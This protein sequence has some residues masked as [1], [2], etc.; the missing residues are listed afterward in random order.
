MAALQN[1]T[2]APLRLQSLDM[3]RGL[4]VAL[5]IV[6]NTSGDG[7]HTFPQLAHSK[8]NG[9]TLADVVF[10]CFLFMVGLSARL[11]TAS[12]LARGA[13]RSELILQAAHR[14]ATLFLLGLAVNSFP[15]F[16]LDTLRIFGVLQ[17]IALCYFLVTCLI[18]FLRPR[19]LSVLTILLLTGYWMILRWV[20][21]PGLGRPVI[22]V[23]FLDR[24]A[25]LPAWLDRHLLSANHL[26]RQTTYDPEGLL[27]SFSALS[28]TMIGGLTGVWI[29]S[30]QTAHAIARGLLLAGTICILAGL[31]W[32]PWFPLNKRLWTSSFV[33]FTAGI[34]ILVLWIFYRFV[35][36]R[37][38]SRGPWTLPL[39]VF[40]TNALPAYI[41]SEFLAS[42]LSAIHLN[43][44]I[45]LQRWLYSPLPWLLHNASVAALAYAILF[46][47]VCFIPTWIL[48][49]RGIFLKV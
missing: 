44:G 47:A 49:R 25:N 4:T 29:R 1:D 17:R 41:L 6:V 43:A 15:F 22:D 33:L 35:D 26:Y 11:S 30:R 40:G 3:L 20:P 19:T 14:S 18:V 38:G 13:S 24:F 42:T 37:S 36:L 8:W 21:I 45:S 10:P 39:L 2:Q 28:S 16:H 7:S 34:S 12:R 9:C 23:P 5:M 48:Y 31:A 32:S 46:T 27:S